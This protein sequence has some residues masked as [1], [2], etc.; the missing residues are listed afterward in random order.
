MLKGFDISTANTQE[1]NTELLKKRISTGKAIMF[2]GAGFSFGTKNTLNTEPPLAGDLAKMLCSLSNL[3]ESE[4][5]MFAADVA[6]EYSDNNKILDLLKDQFTLSEVSQSHENICELPWRRYYTTNYDNSIE[7]AGLNVGR[8]IE[9]IDLMSNPSIYLKKNNVCLHINGKIEGAEPSDLKS[10]IKLS[11]SSYL[12]PDSFV[13]SDWYY[14]FKKELESSSA[15]VFIGYS[16]Y[17]MDVKK[18]LFENPSL[19][20]KTYFVVR[21]G[22]RFQEI[23]TLRKYGH[24][25][26]I[27]V[28]EF[29]KLV[30][31]IKKDELEEGVIFTDSLLRYENYESQLEYRD[32]DSERLFLY[33]DYETNKLHDA[34]RRIESIPYFIKRSVVAE[35]FENVR[36]DKNILVISD[37]GNGKS[38]ILEMLAYELVINGYHTYFL[39]ENGG[40]YIADLDTISNSEDAAVVIVDNFSNYPDLIRH[41]YETQYENI[42]YVLADRNSTL[43]KN[44]NN[45][46]FLQY[47]VDLLTTQEIS[48]TIKI[49]DNL[50]AW[51]EFSALP[52]ER[53]VNL[54]TEKYGS[55]LSLLLLGLLN[56]P[57]IRHKIKHQTDL[58]YENLEFKKTVFAICICEVANVEPT[59]S[60]VSEISGS[61]A[62]YNHSLR[63]LQPFKQLFNVNGTTIKSKSSILSLSLLNNTFQDIYTRDTLLEI[64]E[65][66]D[67]IDDQDVEIK[68]VFKSLLRFHT[69]ERILPQNQSVLDSYYERLKLKCTWLM[70][71]PHY[72]VQYAMCRLSFS[73]YVRAQKYL[74][75]AYQKAANKNRSYHTD[76]IDTQQARLYMLQS[77][78]TAN[79]SESF[80]L[81]DKAHRLLENLPL[82]GRKFRQVLLYKKVF[83]SK[84]EGYNKK[85]KVAFEHASKKMLEQARS[86]ESNNDVINNSKMVKFI[87]LAEDMLSEIIGSIESR[88]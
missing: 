6:L 33:G 42:R 71:S 80:K 37:L 82:E 20:E 61:N 23:F 56:S 46:E 63:E 76:N 86:H 47:H 57:N 62:I 87:F 40:D 77:I 25:L 79:A 26:P 3:P 14:H 59:A 11:D 43:P 72:W 66:T 48:D 69:V 10:N 19:Q 32:I 21:E 60:L 51:N 53:K 65:R 85:N 54:V 27:G 15:I 5:L 49:L 30:K 28:D 1:V 83:E 4:D 52:F 64:V 16:M 67:S 70:D 78:D 36:E 88:R 7:L 81:F 45:I 73:D 55:Q 58:I 68:N 34:L 74:T 75:N 39:K 84:Y 17:D 24:V 50:A 8:R 29:S 35:C 41:I 13:N 38:I 12:S 2:T 22:A 44:K 18:Y 31:G 9:S